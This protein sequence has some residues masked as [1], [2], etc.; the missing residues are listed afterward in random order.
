VLV[1]LALKI[2]VRHQQSVQR[3]AVPLRCRALPS[4]RMSVGRGS[5]LQHD[6]TAPFSSLGALL[7][8]FFPI[9]G[10]LVRSALRQRLW[11]MYMCAALLLQ[12]SLTRTTDWFHRL[13]YRVRVLMRISPMTLRPDSELSFIFWIELKT[14]QCHPPCWKLSKSGCTSLSSSNSFIASQEP[15]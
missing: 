6:R 8:R 15:G 1:H 5:D 9:A 7:Q 4:N 3:G 10:D 11:M 2:E 12:L 13:L 14:R